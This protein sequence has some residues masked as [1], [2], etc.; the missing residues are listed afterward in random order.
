MIAFLALLSAVAS[1]KPDTQSVAVG[2]NALLSLLAVGFAV[3]AIWNIASTYDGE[4][5]ADLGRNLAM[6]VWLTLGIAPAMYLFYLLTA[7]EVAFSWGALDRLSRL[8]RLKARV[9][10]LTTGGHRPSTV[11]KT[12]KWVTKRA[13]EA[14]GMRES[15]KAFRDHEAAVKEKADKERAEQQRLVDMAGISGQDERGRQ[16]DRREFAETVKALTWL[17]T[18]QMGQHRNVGRYRDDALQI[19]GDFERHGIIGDHAIQMTVS[20]DGRRWW[21][22]RRTITGWVFAIGSAKEPPDRWQFD[23]PEPPTG[24]PGGAP[25]WGDR[26]FSTDASRNW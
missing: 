3:S 8:Q 2:A 11:A 18:V 23:G 14:I 4:D 12:P 9:A 6:P 25:E 20:S 16:L 13:A 22:Y 26:A 5:Y 21:A 7:Y 1:Q 24:F 15:W 10:R 17:G 19:I